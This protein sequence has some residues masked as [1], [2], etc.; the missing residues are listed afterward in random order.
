MEERVEK[1]LMPL[2]VFGHAVKR[3]VTER[4]KT[5]CNNACCIAVR[6]T[7]V[8]PAMELPLLFCLLIGDDILFD[9]HILLS[10][11][12]S[13]TAPAHGSSHASSGIQQKKQKAVNA[14]HTQWS[15]AESWQTRVK[16]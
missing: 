6:E 13:N 14:S 8:T 2:K 10:F 11:L 1:W 3:P 16:E 4:T 15:K 12:P 7:N 5:E 9:I